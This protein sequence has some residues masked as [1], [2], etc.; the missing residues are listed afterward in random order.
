M[1]AI[2]TISELILPTHFIC[3]ELESAGVGLQI[4]VKQGSEE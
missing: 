1:S 2:R 3:S 4:F